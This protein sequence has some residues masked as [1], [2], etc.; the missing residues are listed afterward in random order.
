MQR[1][2]RRTVG[3]V[4]SLLVLTAGCGS[5]NDDDAGDSSGSDEPT[6]ARGIT[7]DQITIGFEYVSSGDEALE[8]GGIEGVTAGDGHAIFEALIDRVN[9][10]GGVLGR[11]IV[12]VYYAADAT[13]TDPA[14][15]E[16]A[17]C[18]AFTQDAEVFAAL[19]FRHTESALQCLADAGVVTIG[20]GGINAS[21]SALFEQFPLYVEAGSLSLDLMAST[22]VDALVDDGF[23]SDDATIG[24]ILPDDPVFIRAYE[25]GLVPALEDAGLE[26]AHDVRVPIDTQDAIS[27]AVQS[28]VLAFRDAGVDRMLL[29]DSGGALLVYL[30]NAADAQGYRPQYAM[31]TQSGGTAIVPSVPPQQLEGSTGIGWLPDFDIPESELETWPAR[32]DCLD[33]LASEAQFADPNARSIALDGCTQVDLL[34]AGLE[35][36]D[37]LDAQGF[38]A[39]IES[40]GDSFEAASIPATRYGPGRHDGVGAVQPLAFDDS[41]TCFRYEGDPR[42][43]D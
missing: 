18:T 30:M 28:S 12:P 33:R 35:A 7:D 2:H 10:D 23:L 25:D 16:Q 36:A 4:L 20:P 6:E 9:A 32:T 31:T 27:A 22:L 8:A 14:A 19:V 1:H 15:D 42:P 43:V 24:A 41:C 29:L 26:V 40:L 21:D 37:E 11:E 17:M 5:T 38:M 34:L 3:V 13:S 39:G